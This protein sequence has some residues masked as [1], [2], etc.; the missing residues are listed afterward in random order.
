MSKTVPIVGHKYLRYIADIDLAT[1]ERSLNTYGYNLFECVAVQTESAKPDR[2]L[3]T[4]SRYKLV[5]SILE[6]R[7]SSS[8]WVTFLERAPKSANSWSK[9]DSDYLRFVDVDAPSNEWARS[10]F[11]LSRRIESV[12]DR[13]RRALYGAYFS[14][15][16]FSESELRTMETFASFMEEVLGRFKDAH[17]KEMF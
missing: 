1:R 15:A 14:H 11:I 17:K 3:L 9:T 6:D 12:R 8:Y 4:T 7:V 2:Y 10:A 13:I 16:S 5:D